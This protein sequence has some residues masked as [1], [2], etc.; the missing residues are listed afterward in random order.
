MP[1]ICGV[2]ISKTRLDAAIGRDGV[3][4]AF[5]NTAEGLADLVAFS[6]DHG[7]ELVVVEASGGLERTAFVFLSEAGLPAA[8]VNAASVR[9]FAQGMGL[10]EKTDRIDARVIAWFAEVKAIAPL[11]PPTQGQSRLKALV[12]RLSQ[13]TGDLTIQKQRLSATE[14][15]EARASLL[16]CIA[17]LRGQAR[18]LEA[19]VAARIEDDPVWSRLAETFAA[20]KGVADRTIARIMAD[21]PEIGLISNKAISKL[22]GLAPIADDSGKRSGKRHIQGGRESV[23]SILFLVAGIVRKYDDSLD[24]FYQRLCAA[25]KPKMVIRIALAHKLLV[26]LN[27]KA[28][29][30]RQQINAY[31]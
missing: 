22:V 24:Q 31:A 26:R 25:G 6:R 2:D 15:A 14:D 3:S 30:T 17:F 23:R 27:A 28:R 29:E 7:V 21:L 13:V 18:Q 9:S 12:R 20:V 19:A 5:A 1:I 8:I 16:Q 10:L 11:A 4:G